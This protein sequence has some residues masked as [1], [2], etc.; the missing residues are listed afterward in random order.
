MVTRAA[1]RILAIALCATALVIN[2][3]C[4]GSSTAP[5]P[6]A[7]SENFSGTLQPLGTDFKTF[8]ITAQGPTDLSVTVN[9]L[10]TVAASTPVTGITIGVG[11]GTVSGA[12]CA[13]QV[14][15]SGAV[16]GQELFPPN[17]ASGGVYCVQV[18]D[19]PPGSTGC[20]STLTEAVNY[21]VTVKHY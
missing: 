15:N 11:I 4:G 14:Y 19:C 7:K 8:S 10:T 3:A 21:S 9:S 1:S 13:M 17:G 16:L 18:F 12:I 2:A 5:T 6:V 20:S